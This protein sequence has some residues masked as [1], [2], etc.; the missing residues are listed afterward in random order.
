MI[1]TVPLVTASGLDREV[2]SS[3]SALASGQ[4]AGSM[5]VKV[6]PAP[7]VLSTVTSPPSILQNCL[8]IA[9]PSPVPP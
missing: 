1:R 8:V 2:L 4:I 5:M 9:R 6:E 3:T 7:G